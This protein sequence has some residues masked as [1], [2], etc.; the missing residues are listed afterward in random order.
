MNTKIALIDADTL[1]F[2]AVHNK[3]DSLIVK[4]LQ[5][6]KDHMNDLISNIMKF[7]KA[8]HYLLFLTVGRN[9]RYEI[10]PEY[11][12]NRKGLEKPQYF[13]QIKEYLII[14]Y[15]AVYQTGLEAD[16][17]VCIYKKNLSD[18]F[19]CSP[20]KDIINLE[21]ECFDY[22]NFKWVNTTK[23]EADI[24]FWKSVIK[25]DNI[26]GIKGLPG[27]GEVFADGIKQTADL[28]NIPIYTLILR[29][30]INHFGEYA[31]VQEFYKNY[32]CLKMKDEYE[33]LEIVEP[34]E[35]MTDEKEYKLVD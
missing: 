18:S 6:C 19:I 8:T 9:F 7:T 12:G 5:D 3:K 26:D 14:N 13:D 21:G 34:I 27:K 20:D 33:G 2:F 11:K 32:M 24:Y 17:L 22:K 30:Y 23:E 4:S 15:K 25:G 28:V 35:W 1:I 10:Y 29:E 31:G 16:D